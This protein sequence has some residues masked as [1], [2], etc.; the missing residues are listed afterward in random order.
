MEIAVFV[1]RAFAATAAVDDG[2]AQLPM[3]QVCG[4]RR[5]GI[6]SMFSYDCWA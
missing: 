6:D 3:I 2:K 4:L 1:S 5:A